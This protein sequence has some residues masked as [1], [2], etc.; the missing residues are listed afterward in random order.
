MDEADEDGQVIKL[1]KLSVPCI[2]E[3]FDLTDALE[4]LQIEIEPVAFKESCTENEGLYFSKNVSRKQ[5]NW[6]KILASKK[7]KRKEEKHRRKLNHTERSVNC[8]LHSK[9]VLKA[10]TKERL[11]E[12]RSGGVKLCIDLSMMQYMSTKETS[13]LAAQIRRLYGSNKKATNPFH[14]YLTDFSED[15]LLYKEC[16][17]MN[18]G[19]L[20][21]VMERTEENCLKIFP[22]ECVIYLTPDSENALE[23]VDPEKVYI[24]GGLVDESVQKSL[25]Y[26]KAQEYQLCTARLP[27]EEYMVKKE[28]AKNFHSQILAIN[29][30]FDILVAFCESHS[31]IEAFKVGFPAGKG[32]TLRTELIQ[33]KE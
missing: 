13:R 10:I 24:L 2:Q 31:W 28:N 25:T 11:S 16:V 33:C 26:E 21:Y 4:L 6:E 29:Q 8:N 23:Y 9:R 32:Y 3:E 14:L 20:N 18:D 1:G 30:V 15:S 7:S 22:P 19:F 12:A 27:V 5:K 17:R